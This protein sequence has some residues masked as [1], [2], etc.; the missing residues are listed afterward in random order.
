MKLAIVKFYDPTTFSN[1]ATMDE[2][3]K[4]ACQ[5]CVARGG[6]IEETEEWVKVALLCHENDVAV[7]NWIVIPALNII[8]LDVVDESQLNLGGEDG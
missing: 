1:W 8:S 4:S 5:V 6:L 7:S 3:D 2:V